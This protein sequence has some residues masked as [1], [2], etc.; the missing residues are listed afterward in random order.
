[1]TK[2]EAYITKIMDETGLTR[3]EIQKLVDEKKDELKGLISTEGALYIIARELGIDV[4]PK[5]KETTSIYIADLQ[6]DLKNITVV[7]RIKKIYDPHYFTKKDGGEGKV[8]NFKIVDKTGDIRVVIW[9]DLVDTLITTA[10]FM[11]NKLIK[12]INGYM[13][14]SD[15][16]NEYELHL[17][18]WG[19][20][21]FNPEVKNSEEYPEVDTVE[22]EF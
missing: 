11:E 17:A 5:V 8:I 14:W 3:S 2:E 19:K 22:D 9:D 18:R 20:I 10:E 4:T 7:G 13:K 15:Y 12:I 16:W 1:L 6:K 21:E